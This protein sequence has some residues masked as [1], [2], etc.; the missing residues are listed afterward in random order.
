[1]VRARSSAWM[2]L[3]RRALPVVAVGDPKSDL[4]E[5][6][7]PRLVYIITRWINKNLYSFAPHRFDYGVGGITGYIENWMHRVNGWGGEIHIFITNKGGVLDG[8][9]LKAL[10]RCYP[11]WGSYF[12]GTCLAKRSLYTEAVSDYVVDL[13]WVFK[14]A[15]KLIMD[16]S[17]VINYYERGEITAKID[18]QEIELPI[19]EMRAL[20][21]YIV[22][23]RTHIP[24]PIKQI[25]VY[26]PRLL[27]R[28]HVKGRMLTNIKYV[29]SGGIYDKLF[30][31]V[32][33]AEVAPSPSWAD[34]ASDPRLRSSQDL[35]RT[36]KEIFPAMPSPVIIELIYYEK[37]K[38]IACALVDSAL[39]HG[40]DIE[41]A[42]KAIQR[43]IPEEIYV[44]VDDTPYHVKPD[45][46]LL[47]IKRLGDSIKYLEPM[48][49]N[50]Y[51][52]L[53]RE[54]SRGADLLPALKGEAFS[55][56]SSLILL[57]K[58][59]RC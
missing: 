53:L 27:M 55:C 32:D 46:E 36:V 23:C 15:N 58:P 57:D 39:R 33:D 30:G 51:R 45:R 25:A 47:S 19:A 34:I 9:T 13:G 49:N 56:N 10:E 4:S 5:L 14:H 3:L 17:N 54:V 28:Y 48:V 43:Y 35:R 42:I 52:D 59:L 44:V 16:L 11:W 7:D 37:I 8:E 22:D 21:E 20:T 29:A 12:E 50:Y 38:K 26:I 40:E 18:G 41:T 6:R 24:T 1:L 2:D 31:E